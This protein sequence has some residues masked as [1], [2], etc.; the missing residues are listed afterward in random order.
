MD[1]KVKTYFFLTLFIVVFAN[2]ANTKNK[3]NL[4]IALFPIN[5]HFSSA[6][7]SIAPGIE[8]AKTADKMVFAGGLNFSIYDITSETVKDASSF[9]LPKS[10]N[11]YGEF[12]YI[13]KSKSGSRT[14]PIYTQGP[15]LRSTT[16]SYTN[17]QGMGEWEK[18][19]TTTNE[20]GP[21]E[22]TGNYMNERNV[23][24][25]CLHGGISGGRN[26]RDFS[27]VFDNDIKLPLLKPDGNE[28]LMEYAPG[29]LYGSAVQHRIFGGIQHLGYTDF[30]INSD[31][32]FASMYYSFNADLMILINEKIDE[33]LYG[34]GHSDQYYL[35]NNT[36]KAFNSKMF[37]LQAGANFRLHFIYTKINLAFEPGTGGF[38]TVM[39]IGI[40][41]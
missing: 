7:G 37:G 12:S 1:S 28:I 35:S 3:N 24:M 22:F 19:T 2:Q 23:S 14:F 38:H 10:W 34:L 8:I 25:Q 32:K 33:N 15:L 16:R 6:E 5:G 30:S 27:N 17:Y 36:V 18:V 11:Y 4:F 31:S 40:V 39:S 21:G 20:Y 29:G 13:L 26:L 9:S 41:L